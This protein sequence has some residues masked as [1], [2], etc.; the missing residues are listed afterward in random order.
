MDGLRPHRVPLLEAHRPVVHAARQPEAVF[1]ERRLAAEVAA[2]H[3]ADLRNGDVAL[4]GEHQR[5]V[6]QIFEQ[7]GRRLAGLSAGQPARIVLDAGAAAGRLHHL[8]VEG[9]ALLEPLGLQQPAHPG[10]LGEARVELGLDALHGL[11]QRRPRRHVMRV[12]VDLHGRHLADLLAGQR[13]ELV[14]RLDLVAEQADPP[15]AVLI[16]RRKDL[17]RVAAHP[18]GAAHEVHV[19]ALVLQRHQVGHQLALR[20]RLADL[21]HEGHRGVGLDRADAVDAAHRGDDDDVVAL[22]QG[23]RRGVPHPVD[24]LVDRGFLLDIGVRPRHIGLGLVVVVVGDEVLHRV[25]GE[26]R[27][28]LAI[29]LR[30]QRLVRREDQRRPLGLLDDLGHREGLARAG[31]AEQHLVALLAADAV[32]QLGDRGR[33][34]ALR[35]EGRD[36][37]EG[38][39]ALQLLGPRR[40]VRHPGLALELGPAVL[41]QVLERPHGRGHGRLGVE[42]RRQGGEVGL[43]RG[44]EAARRLL[45]VGD[46]ARRI[47]GLALGLEGC[48]RRSPSPL[49]GEGRG[50]GWF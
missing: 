46:R 34:V 20:D 17:D 22:Q 45:R 47:G 31:D 30:R 10:Q 14:D 19:G 4:V 32:H 25:L 26:E 37:P 29:E 13:V 38:L 49:A 7:R 2:I 33:L 28:E 35:L 1:G 50:G 18:E 39:A 23:P 6:G 11:V 43:V 9:G 44:P 21:Q 42:I 16:V 15:G 41:D 48:S 24:L 36:Q 5:V 12:G 27:L 8:E 40:A 3:A